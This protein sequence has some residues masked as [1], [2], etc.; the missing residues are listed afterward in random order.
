MFSTP[1]TLLPSRGLLYAEST[2]EIKPFGI[3]EMMLI[4]E[5]IETNDD[6]PFVRAVQ[7]STNISSPLT[8]G[9]FYLIAAIQRVLTF[10]NSPIN[11]EWVCTGEILNFTANVPVEGEE[12][13]ALINHFRE[14]GTFES[15]KGF[16]VYGPNKI[17]KVLAEL[18]KD[19]AGQYTGSIDYCQ[20]KNE[21]VIT[22]ELLMESTTRIDS[23]FSLAS[24]DKGYTL[25][26]STLIP[27]Y[28]KLA[29]N[30]R[31]RKLLP[32]VSW[33]DSS[34]GNTLAEKIDV[35]QRTTDGMDIL[36]KASVYDVK[37]QHG[38]KRNIVCP[39]CIRCN[40]H[41][42]TQHFPITAQSFYRR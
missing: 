4:S 17:R 1:I 19:F 20:T 31:V 23:E 42:D 25:P 8:M 21:A 40:A 39:P 5:A 18:Q 32:L 29:T 37:F 38:L 16:E 34:Y 15:N 14:A 3:P 33:L 24:L 6:T 22:P 10:K 7:E 35:L 41:T 28:K 9:D 11:W 30:D 26:L 27:E 36:D 12:V 13:P 2:V